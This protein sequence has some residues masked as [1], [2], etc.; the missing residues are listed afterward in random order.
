MLIVTGCCI[1]MLTGM[2]VGAIITSTASSKALFAFSQ[3]I[4]DIDAVK[5]VGNR[6]VFLG[7]IIRGWNVRLS[8]SL[9]LSMLI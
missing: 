4:S 7:D 1:A 6:R 3:S 2:A 9:V 5:G 8:V